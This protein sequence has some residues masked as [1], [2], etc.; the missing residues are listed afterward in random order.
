MAANRRVVGPHPDGWQVKDPK[1][2]RASGVFDTQAKA[3]AMNLAKVAFDDRPR[4]DRDAA[5]GDGGADDP[6]SQSV[7]P[8]THSRS[9]ASE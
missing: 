2:S 7:N 1:A 5:A 8:T 6:A 3:I 4:R 9:L